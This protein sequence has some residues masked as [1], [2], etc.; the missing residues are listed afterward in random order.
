M[1]LSPCDPKK[2]VLCVPKASAF[3]ISMC[4]RA[5]VRST[6]RFSIWLNE[7]EQTVRPEITVHTLGLRKGSVGELPRYTSMARH[8]T[9]KRM[10]VL[11]AA[12]QDQQ[13]ELNRARK[14]ER[15]LRRKEERMRQ[16]SLDVCFILYVRRAPSGSLAL[17]YAAHVTN[18]KKHGVEVC[19]EQLE[20]RYLEADLIICRH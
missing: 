17:A 15:N 2:R 12:M 6:Q 1:S 18:A 14:A 20:C 10:K 16:F 7:G 19:I 11:E 4:A 9:L 3:I 13:Q 5:C 8:Q